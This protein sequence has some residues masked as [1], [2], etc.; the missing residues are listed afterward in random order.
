VKLSIFALTAILVLSALPAQ[1]QR[2]AERI[3]CYR[4]RNVISCPEYEDFNIRGNYND[5]WDN[6]NYNYDS[7]NDNRGDRYDDYSGLRAVNEIYVQVLGRKTDYDGAK[8]CIQAL[9]NGWTLARVRRDIAYSPEAQSVI[10]QVYID[11]L[12]RNADS[13]GME[14]YRNSLANGKSIADVRRK[15]A[16]SPEARN[17]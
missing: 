7:R 11:I 10:N 4:E 3:T 14:T 8:T 17:R 16:R 2:R 6:D 15:L 12:R 5:R 13:S 1:A 9:N